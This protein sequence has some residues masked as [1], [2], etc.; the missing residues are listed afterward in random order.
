[1]E[2]SLYPSGVV[3]GSKQD[4]TS[5]AGSTPIE[6]EIGN[7]LFCVSVLNPIPDTVP[8]MS[9]Q[10]HFAAAVQGRARSVDLR[11]NVLARNILVDHPVNGLNL[12]D[13]L[14]Q[15]AMQVF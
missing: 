2:S 9:L 4:P 10:H 12:T 7:G 14:F 5:I 13:D 8:D 11:E 15:A 3:G 1:M 6:I